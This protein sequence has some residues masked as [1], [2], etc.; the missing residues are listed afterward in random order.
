MSPF[1]DQA[2]LVTG[3]TDGIGLLAAERLARLGARVLLHGRDPAKLRAAL[4][5]V[6]GSTPLIADLSD[7]RQVER[8]A[9]AV[10]DGPRLAL[11]VNNAGV[12]SGGPSGRRETSVD[13]YELR[14]A[15]NFLAPFA[16][17]EGL[18]ARAG[19]GPAAVVNVASL[20][21]APLD[22]DD[23]GLEQS[24]GGSLAY[25]RSKLALVTWTLDLAARRPELGVNALHPGTYLDTR[26]VRDAAIAPRGTAESGADAV[27]EVARRTVTG[28]VRGVFFDRDQPSRALGEAYDPK[29]QER[30][31]RVAQAEVERALQRDAGGVART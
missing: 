24:Y 23:P 26:M 8:L 15:V 6:P 28:E 21:Q 7:L 25:A 27:V 5:R 18:L 10:A 16:L 30:L 14:W 2:V 11:L 12:G 13:G 1:T 20:G 3:A 9:D 4:A 19:G 29:L 22:L 17:T 31:R